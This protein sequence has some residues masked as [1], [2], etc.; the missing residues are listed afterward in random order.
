MSGG[1]K[2][3]R[4]GGDCEGGVH[5]D[6]FDIHPYTTGGPTHEERPNDVQLGDL[7]K[8]QVLLRAARRDNRILTA[9]RRVPLWITEF[10]W[11]TKPSDPGGL[12]M[13]IEAR[14]IPEAMYRAWKAGVSSFFWFSLQDEPPGS[15]YKETLQSGLYFAGATV[16]ENQPKK[17]FYAFRFP[18]V[19]YP[20]ESGLSFWGRTPG[21]T[22]GR[23][24]IE[25]IRRGK[26]RRVASWKANRNGLFEGVLGS[27]YG[28]DKSGAVRAVVA[29]V[30]SV[31]FSMH[32]VK[33]FFHPPFG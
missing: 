17:I 13:R 4:V 27:P 23:V 21:G 7:G 30:A 9:A 22:A 31:P 15:S 29:G 32:P 1:R 6:I 11:D 20:V 16:A 28:R 3:R 33:D 24:A 25:V 2:P 8:L 12:P 18:F 26:W 5:F 19:A 14:W 10:S